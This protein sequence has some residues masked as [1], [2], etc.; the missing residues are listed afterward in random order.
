MNIHVGTLEK[1]SRNFLESIVSRELF[2]WSI[3]FFVVLMSYV[4][5]FF[6]WDFDDKSL[7][8][9]TSY[10]TRFPNDPLLSKLQEHLQSRSEELGTY[11]YLRYHVRF[12]FPNSPNNFMAQNW[13]VGVLEELPLYSGY[14]SVFLANLSIHLLAVGAAF[15]GFGRLFRSDAT[16]FRLCFLLSLSPTILFYPIHIGYLFPFQ[17]MFNNVLW[18]VSAPRGAALAF[19][20]AS[21]LF[22]LSIGGSA[23]SRA[24]RIA[25]ALLLLAAS[26]F[27]HRSMGL[28]LVGTTLVFAVSYHLLKVDP[29]EMSRRLGF[30]RFLFLFNGL[31]AVVAISKLLFLLF[32]GSTE[33]H[34]LAP[35]STPNTTQLVKN[36]LKLAFWTVATNLLAFHWLKLR[37]DDNAE[38][39]N[40]LRAGDEFFRYLLPFAIIGIGLNVFHP[41]RIL[42]WSSLHI[43]TEAS[44]RITGLTHILWWMVFGIWLHSKLLNRYKQG[45]QTSIAVV[46]LLLCV[47]TIVQVLLQD[48]KREAIAEIFDR[49]KLTIQSSVLLARPGIE[50]YADEA[51]YYQAIAN[52]LRKKNSGRQ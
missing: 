25:V 15:L 30:R 43:P 37:V 7:L 34:V 45:L 38:D 21:L 47:T 23:M 39:N 31:I 52:E 51:R 16:L 42:W 4:G 29:R 2:T 8:R 28:L 22:W 9:A 44:V 40:V 10:M 13:F 26:I 35:A 46:L 19:F 24:K 27:S 18:S 48:N 12:G 41:G 14:Q 1:G 11:R 49:G 6:I 32:Y 3:L 5:A 36:I 20:F 33:F 17:N 50:A